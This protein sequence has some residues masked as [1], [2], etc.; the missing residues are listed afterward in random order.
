MQKITSPENIQIKKICALQS[1][2]GR[3]TQQRFIAQGQRVITTFL[4]QNY[5]LEQICV[6][7]E[8]LEQAHQIA[9][10][11]STI[12]VNTHLMNKISTVSTP[13]GIVAVFQIPETKKIPLA[14]GLVLANITDPGNMGTLIRTAAAMGFN[15]VIIIEGCDPW[16][17]KVVQASAGT[18]A[19]VS[20]VSCTW[21]ALV[22][23]KGALSLCAL[24]VEQGMPPEQLTLK[25]TL[26][27]VGNE[28]HGLPQ[29]WIDQCEQCMTIPMP[30][31]T[32]SLNAAVAGSIALYAMAIAKNT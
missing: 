30:G 27:V 7:N 14:P 28:A 2:K 11:A 3:D 21:P 32:E 18:L 12:L 1:K 4:A 31:N 15:T 16:S 29:E 20:L 24:A 10:G 19:Y 17:P 13:S 25:N 26:L 5:H 6:T 23:Q 22:A 8:M 9:P